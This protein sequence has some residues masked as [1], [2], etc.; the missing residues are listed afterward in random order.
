VRQAQLAQNL[1]PIFGAK[2]TFDPCSNFECPGPAA[3][4][5]RFWYSK[6]ILVLYAHFFHHITMDSLTT[7]AVRR[8]HFTQ[9]AYMNASAQVRI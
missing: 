6:S 2:S 8:Y 7:I 3:A 4:P 1:A 9:L 5:N